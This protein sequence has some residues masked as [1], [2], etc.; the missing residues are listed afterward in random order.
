MASRSES[1]PPVLLRPLAPKLG[2]PILLCDREVIEPGEG[3][4]V[5]VRSEMLPDGKWGKALVFGGALKEE[6]EDLSSP[7]GG[8]GTDVGRSRRG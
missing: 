1:A 2:F 7:R 6:G 3:S 5:L 4:R 8:A